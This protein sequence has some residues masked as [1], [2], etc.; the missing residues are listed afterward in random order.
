MDYAMVGFD[1]RNT[2]S[3]F[4]AVSRGICRVNGDNFLQDIVELTNIERDG[5]HARNID[6]AGRITRLSGDEVVSMNMWGFTPRIFG[7]LKERFQEFLELNASDV[8]A[9]SYLSSTVNELVLA[10]LARVKVLRTGDSW[11]GVTYLGDRPRVV[12]SICRLVDG[13]IYPQRLWL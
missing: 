9:E 4:G 11:V 6:A 5:V 2:L 1:L 12:E 13:G 3:D 8:Q 7:H 10:R